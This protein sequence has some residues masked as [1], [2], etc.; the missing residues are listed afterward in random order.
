MHKRLFEPGQIGGLHLKNR[1]FMAPMVRNWGTPE[2]CSTPR[3]LAHIERVARGGVGA[4]ILEASYV[5]PEGKGFSRQLGVHDDVIIAPLRELVEAARRHGARIGVQLYHAGR[6]THA[7]I[8]GS[9]PVGASDLPCPLG[10]E[11][12]HAL[13]EAEI[14]VLVRRFAEAARRCV[15]AGCDFVELHGAHGYLITQFLSPFSNTRTDG[16]GGSP[17]RRF[18][19]LREVFEAVRA[20]TGPEFP[21]TV[22]LSGDE[23]VPGGLEIEDTVQIARWLEAL[24]AA[25][26]HVSAANYASYAKG[27]MISPMSVP[28]AP[29]ANLAE[30]VREAVAV[31][32]I[33]VNKIRTPERAERMLAEGVCD[34]IAL[35]RPLLADPYWPLKAMDDGVDINLCIACNEGCIGRLFQNKDAWCVVNPSAGR[36]EEFD[37]DGEIW[38]R[39]VV[40]IGGG[41]AGLSAAIT[42]ATRGHKVVLFESSERLG[43]QLLPAAATPHRPGWDELRRELATHLRLTD[44]DVRLGVAATRDLVE[45]E[46]PDV[47]ILATGARPKPASWPMQPGIRVVSGVDALLDPGKVRG[48][49]V[50]AGGGCSGAQTAEAL[51]ERQGRPVTVVEQGPEIAKEAPLDDRSLLLARLERLKVS[52]LTDTKITAAGAG[53]V[54]VETATGSRNLE[55]ETLVLCHGARSELGLVA[56]LQDLPATLITVGDCASPRRVMEALLEGARAGLHLTQPVAEN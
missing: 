6:Q 55:A 40:V 20:A 37:S 18:R 38:P 4:I 51:A 8:T 14:A 23:M 15:A 52:L 28:D 31:P 10:Q 49:V 34:F 16:Y 11:A 53:A 17:E 44:T 33:A 35:A 41:P 36:E 43:G 29:L 24:G 9:Q 5:S 32:V 22:R 39:K 30:R 25:A 2:G 1:L 26:I 21:I 27:G 19:F 46:S 48:P 50:V 12:T 3:Y 56:E 42:A 47:I 7:A 45:A 13:S 54:K